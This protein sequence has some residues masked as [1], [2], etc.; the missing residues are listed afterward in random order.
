[1]PP[2]TFDKRAVFVLPDGRINIVSFIIEAKRLDETFEVFMARELEKIK[3]KLPAMA[4]L[5]YFVKTKQEIVD[6][7]GTHPSRK[8]RSL[9]CTQTGDFYH[10]MTYKTPKEVDDELKESARV[11]LISGTPLTDQ[12]AR[13]LLK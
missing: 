4:N 3:M 9:R 8:K 2:T 12:E 5:P 11:K 10:D 7:I 1:M 6:A 13:R